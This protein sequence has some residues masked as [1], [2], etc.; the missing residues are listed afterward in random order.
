ME[1]DILYKDEMT[2]KERMIAFSKGEE[3]DRIPISPML[4]E[5][6]A[7][8][9]GYKMDE[10]AFSSEIMS[11]VEIESFK[12]FRPDSISIGISLRGMGEAMG[13]IL[14]FPKD[15]ISYVKEP[16]VKS[17]NDIDKLKVANPKKDGRLPIFLEALIRTKDS[18]GDEVNVGSSIV[19]PYS[20]AACL[21]GAE[22]LLKW[23][24]KFPEKVKEL[25]EIITESNNNFIHELANIGVSVSIA[26]PVSSPTLLGKKHFNNFSYPYL[27]NNIETITALTGKKP[28]IHI[29]GKSKDLWKP[30]SEIGIS[31]FSIDN[32]E[33]LNEVKEIIGNETVIVGNVP[34]VEVI[35]RGTKEDIYASVKECILKGKDSPK[36][37]ILSSGCQ[38]PMYTSEENI[39]HFINAGKHY[40]KGLVKKE[41][42]V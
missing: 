29:C 35:N 21:T 16:F 32:I 14:E 1:C 41:L 20:V 27:K 22:N 2:P 42:L 13:S 31:S 25:M 11:N 34:P 38:I 33:D 37:F 10:Y 17:V 7:P 3:I 24:I 18:I 36:G 6:V 19:G 26:D 12:R 30:L 28:G 39:M 5:T 4:G 40:S 15:A 9:Y 8:L 23:T